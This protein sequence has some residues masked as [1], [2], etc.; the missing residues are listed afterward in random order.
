MG[1]PAGCSVGLGCVA[2]CEVRSVDGPFD[3]RGQWRRSIVTKPTAMAAVLLFTNAL[4]ATFAQS[5]RDDGPNASCR[6]A[7]RS[8]VRLSGA[9]GPLSGFQRVGSETAARRNSRLH[10]PWQHSWFIETAILAPDS[11]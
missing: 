9:Q 11:A 7:V 10:V 8:G 4:S 1:G 2:S 5:K 6:C 3:L